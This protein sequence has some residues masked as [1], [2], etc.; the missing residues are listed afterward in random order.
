[1]SKST[2][3]TVDQSTDENDE[4]DNEKRMRA[5]ARDNIQSRNRASSQDRK[6][7]TFAQQIAQ[8]KRIP[9]YYS[10]STRIPSA[11]WKEDEEEDLQAA[12]QQRKSSRKAQ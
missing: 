1:M 12:P 2:S 10:I 4:V 6:S 8:V 5:S 3:G 9:S 7:A 11:Y